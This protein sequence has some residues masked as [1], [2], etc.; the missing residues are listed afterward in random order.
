MLLEENLLG[1][2]LI[3]A[4]IK[5]PDLDNFIT[6]TYSGLRRR[7]I[8]LWCHKKLYPVQRISVI[9]VLWLKQSRRKQRER[10]EFISPTDP[11]LEF[12]SNGIKEENFR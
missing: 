12:Y 3:K 6:C 11:P 4:S 1:R 2:F 9:N 8:P 7:K 5:L 10:M